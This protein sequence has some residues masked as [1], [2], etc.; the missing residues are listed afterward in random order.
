MPGFQVQLVHTPAGQVA[1][2]GGQVHLGAAGLGAAHHGHALVCESGHACAQGQGGVHQHLAWR[3]HD[4]GTGGQLQPRIDD[5]AQ[6]LT[7]GVHQAHVQPGIVCQHGAD[8]RQQRTGAFAPGVAIGAGCRAGD[9]LAHAVVQGRGTVQRG[10]HLHPHPGQAALHAAE[11]TDVQL[12]RGL[13]QRVGGGQHVHHH[14]GGPQ[15]GHALAVD[16]RVGVGLR[17]H[18]A[19]HTSR[20]QR[21]AARWRA[22]VVAARLQRHQRRGTLSGGTCCLRCPQSHHLGMRPTGL[23]GKALEHPAIGQQQAAGHAGV[24]VTQAHCLRGQLVQAD[25]RSFDGRLQVK[26]AGLRG[27]RSGDRVIGSHQK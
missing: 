24:G 25:Q 14:S 21:I 8:A 1:Q 23:L 22:P 10:C 9:P 5:H 16:Q 2:H 19:G 11:K 26:L 3:L 7:G 20:N 4:A 27:R 15:P 18:H 12:P 13:G 17:H 6:R